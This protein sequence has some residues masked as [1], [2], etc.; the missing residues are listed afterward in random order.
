LSDSPSDEKGPALD[1]RLAEALDRSRDEQAV[2]FDAIEDVNALDMARLQALADDLQPV[3]E[4]LPH[5]SDIFVCRIVPGDPPRLW[6]DLLAYV[7]I[8]RDGRG[9]RLVMNARTGRQ[10]LAES[11][12]IREISDHVISYIAHR[13]IDL[14]RAG[15]AVPERLGKPAGGHHSGA[16]VA[17]AWG[18]G[19]AVGLLLSLAG[20]VILAAAG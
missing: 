6:I 13:Y 2:R 4:D 1:T 8:D 20:W 16:V 18:C 11:A 10:I 15:A 7:I 5:D 19:V 12:E 17:L 9:F 3:F 14:E